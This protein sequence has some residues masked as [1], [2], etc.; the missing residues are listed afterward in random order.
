VTENGL[1][2]HEPSG[3][4]IARFMHAFRG[5]LLSLIKALPAAKSRQ[6]E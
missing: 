2:F 3:N 4:E 6:L 1:P 5:P